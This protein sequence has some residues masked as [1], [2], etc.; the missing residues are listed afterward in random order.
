MFY[1]Y[2]LRSESHPSQVYTGYTEELRQRLA[3]A[4]DRPE[5][6]AER[7]SQLLPDQGVGLARVA[8]A[9]RVT[10]DHPGGEPVEHGRG[11]LTG[12]GAGELVVEV[13][14]P[15]LDPGP[16]ER[17]GAIG[18]QLEQQLVGAG[19]LKGDHLARPAKAVVAEADK[20]TVDTVEPAVVLVG[21]IHTV[22][23]V[24]KTAVFRQADTEQITVEQVVLV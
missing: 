8:P 22:T 20:V 12:V 23:M 17:V 11:G 6:G 14:G 19:L 21:S 24:D 4:E 15:D 16:G 3:D 10:E 1:V 2:L 5:P 7:P 18:E 9:L 13:L